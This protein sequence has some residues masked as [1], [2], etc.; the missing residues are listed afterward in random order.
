MDLMFNL[1]KSDGGEERPARLWRWRALGG[2]RAHAGVVAATGKAAVGAVGGGG[3]AHAE[4]AALALGGGKAHAKGAALGL[5]GAGHT[6]KSGRWG[7]G[8]RGGGR[9][10]SGIKVLAHIVKN[11]YKRAYDAQTEQ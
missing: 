7:Q 5:G 3:T 6:L 2:G 9:T 11:G 4:G 8:A 1:H 10:W